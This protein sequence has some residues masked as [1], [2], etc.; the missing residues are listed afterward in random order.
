MSLWKPGPANKQTYKRIHHAEHGE[1]ARANALLTDKSGHP[2]LLGYRGFDELSG[3]SRFTDRDPTG[4][5]VVDFR[6]KWAKWNQLVQRQPKLC[7]TTWA[8]SCAM[9]IDKRSDHHGKRGDQHEERPF[10]P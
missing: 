10:R 9:Q 5:A 3:L 8:T 6:P 7:S 1:R 4:R 2:G